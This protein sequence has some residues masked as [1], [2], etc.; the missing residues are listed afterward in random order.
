MTTKGRSTSVFFPLV[1]AFVLTFLFFAMPARAQ[2]EVDL[3]STSALCKGQQCFNVAGIFATGTTF[4]GTNGMD[5]GMN[6]TPTAPYTNCPDAYSSNQ[7]GL[8]SATPP[9]LTPPSLNV[10][11]VFGPVNTVDCGPSTSTTCTLDVVNLTTSG[12]VI[13]LPTDQQTIYSTLIMLGTAV[14][15]HHAGQVTATYTTGAPDVFKQTFSDW[16]SYGGNQYESPAV[17]RNPAG[18]AMNR[19]NSDGTLNGASCNLYAYTYPLDFTRTL[20]SITLTDE[21]GS[22]FMYGLA[23]T[24]K[25]PTYTIDGG[26]A[27]PA[28]VTAGSMSMATVTVNPQPG[29]VGT[30]TLSCVISPTIVGAP[31]SAA[32][33]PS[34]SLSP[35]SVTVTTGET[36][37]P[38]TMLT[39]TSAASASSTS[40]ARSST[41]IFYAFLLPVSGL[42]L[43]GLGTSGR[44]G[45]RKRWLGFWFVGMLLALLILSPACVSTVHLRNVGTPPGQYSIAVTGVDTNG[46]T[47]ASNPAGTSNVVV[48]NVTD[49]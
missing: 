25:P 27:N 45:R 8:S 20:Q 38:T 17:S 28:S 6:C 2:V 22:G 30:I 11:F 13:T 49:N 21:D 29:Y 42:A 18:T 26:I 39:F 9:T 37:S 23:I 24:L 1:A 14:N 4:L 43:F 19:I 40:Q 15:G 46:L 7:L 36:A 12:V 34:C 31:P 48:V 44:G 16:C 47:Q 10:P 35:A 33:A 41:R 32:T 5:D 3:S